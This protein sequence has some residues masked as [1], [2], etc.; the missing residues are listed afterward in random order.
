MSAV[1]FEESGPPLVVLD[2]VLVSSSG[3]RLIDAEGV[4]ALCTELL[5]RVRVVTPNLPEAEVLSGRTIQSM[6]DARDAIA[7][8][9]FPPKLFVVETDGLETHGKTKEQQQYDLNRQN[10][11]SDACYG[12]RRFIYADVTRRPVHVCRETL[13]GLMGAPFAR[14]PLRS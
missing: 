8:F 14:L 9:G 1:I 5:S 2:P 11:I 4:Q 10:R 7:D 3:D 6:D 13:R 12:F